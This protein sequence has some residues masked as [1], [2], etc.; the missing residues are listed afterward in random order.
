MRYKSDGDGGDD[1]SDGIGY[2]SSCDDSDGGSGDSG[3][4]FT[5]IVKTS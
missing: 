2:D 1:N 4:G 3:D 5:V